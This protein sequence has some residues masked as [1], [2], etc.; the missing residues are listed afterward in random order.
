MKEIIIQ[1][2]TKSSCSFFF[3]HARQS[4]FEKQPPSCYIL[5]KSRIR[6]LFISAGVP[7]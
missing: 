6:F 5:P 3:S 2:S 4:L 1:K 7:A